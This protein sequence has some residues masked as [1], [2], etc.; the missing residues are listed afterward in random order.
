MKTTIINLYGGPGI[1]KSTSAAYMYYK[2]KTMGKNAEL[3]RE[4]VKEWAWEGRQIGPYDQAYFMG[5][6]IRHETMLY[7]KT[8][9]IVTDAPVLMSIPYADMF[10]HPTLAGSIKLAAR[11]MYEQATR[12]GHRHIHV[13]L[14]R[15]KA[16]QPAGRYQTEAEARQL[17]QQLSYLL[18]AEVGSSI[19]HTSST[20]E[21]HL[22]SILHKY[23]IDT[24]A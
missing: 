2:L 1:G 12:D 21:A 8:E 9:F 5:K 7:G 22:T 18:D 19:Y 16:Y 14:T 23:A 15:T 17:D 20:D 10:C 11:A 3:V 24:V 13:M 6:Q 4:Y